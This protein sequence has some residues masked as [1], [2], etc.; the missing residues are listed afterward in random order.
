MFSDSICEVID[1]LLEEVKYYNEE[2]F[3]YSLEYKDFIL[4]ALANLY[5]IQMKLDHFDYNDERI[6]KMAVDE[7]KK[8]IE[9]IEDG[10]D[11]YEEE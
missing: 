11:A 3:G 10:L 1:K 9:R 6:M 4:V 8:R 2:P 5:F 7:A